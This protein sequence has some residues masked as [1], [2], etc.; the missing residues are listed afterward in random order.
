M[1]NK[2]PE[3]KEIV[4]KEISVDD[5]VVQI[6]LDDSADLSVDDFHTNDKKVL[7]LL[8]QDTYLS[9]SHYA[10][11]GLVRKLGIHQQSLARS[12]H[13]LEEVG[14]VKK[15]NAGYKLSKNLD[16]VLVKKSRIDLENLSKR[17]SHQYASFEQILQLYIPTTINVEE[18]V[19]KLVGK[20]F[21]NLRWIGFIDGDN[22][23]V[24]QWASNDKYYVNLKIVSRYA[25]IETNASG[26]KNKSE[27]IISAY[28]ILEQITKLLK[29][30]EKTPKNNL[31]SFNQ[32]N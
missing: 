5:K 30:N 7:S 19:T 24:L 14:L 4:G 3:N 26:Q 28:K 13:R 1:E 9:D 25:I 18:I 8:S 20:W 29:P 21:G 10:F 16:S 6:I 32:Y 15:T 31:I 22:G 11:N 23:C 12:L 2:D 17:I 27:S